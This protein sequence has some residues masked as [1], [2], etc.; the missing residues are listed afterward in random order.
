MWRMGDLIRD[1][2]EEQGTIRDGCRN[3]FGVC[4]RLNPERG[5]ADWYESHGPNLETAGRPWFTFI[6]SPD[7]LS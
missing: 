6:P 2:D 1:G 3:P 7:Q 5:D 4:T